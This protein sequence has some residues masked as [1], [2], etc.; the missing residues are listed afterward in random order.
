MLANA[1]THGGASGRPAACLTMGAG[2]RSMT[3]EEDRRGRAAP[4]DGTVRVSPGPPAGFR[5]VSE[6]SGEIARRA[7]F[8]LATQAAFS[9]LSIF[10]TAAGSSM[11]SI[12]ASSRARRPIAAS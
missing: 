1:S 3:K 6:L 7:E 12:A 10:T 5:R 8:R 2:I 9:T 4:S 11:F